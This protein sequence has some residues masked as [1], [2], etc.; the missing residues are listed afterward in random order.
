MLEKIT[1]NKN[2]I[3]AVVLVLFMIITGYTFGTNSPYILIDCSLGNDIK[4]YLT[5]TSAD[6]RLIYNESEQL[7]LNVSGSTVYGYLERQ[8]EQFQIYFPTYDTPYYR[9][10]NN[11]TYVYITNVTNIRKHG[12]SFYKTFDDST[13]LFGCVAALL[14]MILLKRG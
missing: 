12:V 6:N 2:K 8:G 10:S 11:Y 1:I 14:F 5:T 7:I 13:I 3:I 4:I 9:T